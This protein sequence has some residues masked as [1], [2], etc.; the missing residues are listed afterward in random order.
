M[1][2]GL[3]FGLSPEQGFLVQ[4]GVTEQAL[5][6]LSPLR[7][8]LEEISDGFSKA[9]DAQHSIESAKSL[10]RELGEAIELLERLPLSDEEC[11]ARM[12]AV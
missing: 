10:T 4:R 2:D 6:T 11:R 12:G 7:H 1:A 9:A 5:G 8:H 3:E